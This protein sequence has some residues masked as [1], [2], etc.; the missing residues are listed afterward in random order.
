MGHRIQSTAVKPEP[1]VSF[2]RRV[3]Q[4]PCGFPSS[5]NSAGADRGWVKLGK[6]ALDVL[7]P[8]SSVTS[9]VDAVSHYFSFVTPAPQGIRVDVEELRYFPWRKHFVHSV[10]IRHFLLHLLFNQPIPL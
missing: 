10:I 2:P 3:G 7:E 6:E 9:R 8:I 5:A 4:L 1:V